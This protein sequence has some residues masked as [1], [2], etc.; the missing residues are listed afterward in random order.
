MYKRLYV[1][2]RVTKQQNPTVDTHKIKRKESKQSTMANHQITKKAS[3]REEKQ[4]NNRTARK[5]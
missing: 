1:S 2:L 4:W 5:Q 3:K